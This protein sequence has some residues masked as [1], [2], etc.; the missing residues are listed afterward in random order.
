MQHHLQ[1]EIRV[2]NFGTS[3]HCS[4]HISLVDELKFTI[5]TTESKHSKLL[6]TSAADN[7][8]TQNPLNTARSRACAVAR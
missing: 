3:N 8:T 5:Y 2:T 1:T 6:I 7:S 4:H